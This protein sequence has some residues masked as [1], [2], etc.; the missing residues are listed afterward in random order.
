MTFTEP[1]TISNYVYKPVS[2]DFDMAVRVESLL[3]T[4]LNAR[5]G[6]MARP[7]TVLRQPQRAYRSHPGTLHFPVPHQCR[8]GHPGGQFAAASDGLS[9]L[10]DPAGAE[11]RPFSPAIPAPITVFGT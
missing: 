11:R 6:L 10:L 8:G 4:D 3:N 9:E 7:D 1:T 2:G 5:A